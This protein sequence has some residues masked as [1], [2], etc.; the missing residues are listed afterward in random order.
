M[1]AA[2]DQERSYAMLK[3]LLGVVLANIRVSTKTS[4]L[5]QI[6]PLMV[7]TLYHCEGCGNDGNIDQ[8][9]V[10]KLRQNTRE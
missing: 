9:I 6:T 10:P 7:F 1:S 3:M 5:Y 4:H 2:K 8:Q